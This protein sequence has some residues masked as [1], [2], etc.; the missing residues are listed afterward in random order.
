LVI[1]EI[2]IFKGEARDI[3]PIMLSF[4]DQVNDHDH[5]ESEKQYEGNAGVNPDVLNGA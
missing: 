4:L 5:K 1:V 2:V 3:I